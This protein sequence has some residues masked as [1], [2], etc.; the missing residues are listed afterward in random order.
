MAAVCAQA[1]AEEVLQSRLA[2]IHFDSRISKLQLSMFCRH[3]RKYARFTT[4]YS[5][6]LVSLGGAVDVRYTE[7]ELEGA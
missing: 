1:A 5:R 7:P 6:T 4:S 3:E 2:H